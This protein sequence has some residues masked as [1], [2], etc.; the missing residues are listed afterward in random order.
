MARRRIGPGQGTAPP[1]RRRPRRGPA[2]G[3]VRGL[4]ATGPDGGRAAGDGG[5]A[6]PRG[7][8][9]NRADV[10]PDLKKLG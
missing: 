10:C 9:V 5:V 3:D 2:P 8:A 7:V 1:L 6:P 4:L